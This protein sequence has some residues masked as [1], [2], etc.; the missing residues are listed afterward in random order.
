M[1][2]DL[3]TNFQTVCDNYDINANEIWMTGDWFYT[4]NYVVF[5][6]G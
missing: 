5:G 2:L 1:S 6:D 3:A 4:A